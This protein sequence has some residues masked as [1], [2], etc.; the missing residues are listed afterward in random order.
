MKYTNLGFKTASVVGIGI[1][2]RPL[3]GWLTDRGIRVTARDIK[4][5]QA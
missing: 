5:R 2:N 1:S 4:P 3:I